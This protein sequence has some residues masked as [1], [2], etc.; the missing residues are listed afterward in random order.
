MRDFLLVSTDRFGARTQR[1]IDN[2]SIEL[3]FAFSRRRLWSSVSA[4]LRRN[5]EMTSMNLTE[6]VKNYEPRLGSH[7]RAK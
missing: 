7:V 1:L 5:R 3:D 6:A 4:I 2:L